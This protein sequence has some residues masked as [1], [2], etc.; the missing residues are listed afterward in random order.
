MVNLDNIEVLKTDNISENKFCPQA[1]DLIIQKSK[2]YKN[3]IYNRIVFF[4]GRGNRIEDA[5]L[6]KDANNQKSKYW[7]NIVFDSSPN[8]KRDGA[9]NYALVYNYFFSKKQTKKKK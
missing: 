5:Y 4:F 6:S 8:P 1:V 2:L 9:N 3:K 7:F